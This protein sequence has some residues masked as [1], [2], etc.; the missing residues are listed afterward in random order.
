LKENC[1][2]SIKLWNIA[3]M[4]ILPGLDP[5]PLNLLTSWK[6]PRLS[7]PAGNSQARGFQFVRFELGISRFVLHFCIL[8]NL[9]CAIF[10]LRSPWTL[11]GISSL[12]LSGAGGA[13]VAVLFDIVDIVCPRQSSSPACFFRHR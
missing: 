8:A 1:K 11:A 10:A 2:D 12:A 4:V 5:K 6:T 3:E 7:V 13:A 9:R